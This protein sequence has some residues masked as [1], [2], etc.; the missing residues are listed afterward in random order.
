MIKTAINKLS[1]NNNLELTE[2]REVFDEITS[3]L[4]DETLIS[5]FLTALHLKELTSDELAGAILSCRES[6]K[7]LNLTI[8]NEKTVEN[9]FIDIPEN[10]FDI[11]VAVDLVCC[12]CE[13]G[14]LRYSFETLSGYSNSFKILQLLQ[15]PFRFENEDFVDFFEKN[16]FGYHLLSKN[17]PYFKYTYEIDRKM[18]FDSI[19]KTINLMLNPYT[20]KNQVIGLKSKADVEKMAQT[21][22]KLN[23]A[24]SIII[25]GDNHPFVVGETFVAEA[26]KNKIFTYNLSCDL[27]GLK[28]YTI[29]DLK[30]ENNE[31]CAKII[32]EIFENKRKDEYLDFVIANSALSLYIAKKADSI[33]DAINLAKKVI[34]D[35]VVLQK[36][37]YLKNNL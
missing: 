24:N 14:A 22:L 37:K 5:S 18:P 25:S 31:H 11:N 26:W 7:K 21:C 28:N 34:N 36:I 4:A 30:V 2:I 17:E 15:I 32:M 9:I 33:M 12:A 8:N 10:I 29:D 23:N 19:F 1:E 3:G 27:I 13:L 16:F 6:I 20:T 35:G